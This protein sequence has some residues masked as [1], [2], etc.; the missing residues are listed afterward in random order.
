M[1]PER[2]PGWPGSDLPILCGQQKTNAL[3]SSIDRVRAAFP[4]G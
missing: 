1:T 2:S 3:R 4:R